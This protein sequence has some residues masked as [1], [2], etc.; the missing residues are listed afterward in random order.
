MTKKKSDRLSFVRL[1]AAGKT[2]EEIMTLTGIPRSTLFRWKSKLLQDGHMDEKPRSGRPSMITPRALRHLSRTA[3]KESRRSAS[4][5]ARAAGLNVDEKLNHIKYLEILEN[6]VDLYLDEIAEELGDDI[7]FQ[8]DNAR[9]HRA[10][11]VI[12]FKSQCTWKSTTWPA[13]SPDLNPIEHIW[14]FIKKRLADITPEPTSKEEWK[15]RI[16]RIW[17]EVPTE[18]CEKLILGMSERV[19]QLKDEKG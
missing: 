18:M 16:R 10:K 7:I 13:Q 15:K 9:P 5:I 2:V 8:D 12:T 17:A 11:R 1:I 19:S 4:C 14:A 3:K 6:T